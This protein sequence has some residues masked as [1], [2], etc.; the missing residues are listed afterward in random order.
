MSPEAIQSTDFLTAAL[1]GSISSVAVLVGLFFYLNYHTRRD[2]FTIW[3]VAWLFYGVWLV[4]RLGIAAD[5]L[6]GWVL[7]I[8]QWCIGTSAVFLLWGVCRF[9]GLPSPQR[10]MALFL[11]FIYSWAYA[12][13]EMLGDQ[14]WVQCPVF[15]LVGLASVL[16]AIGFYRIRLDH[17]SVGATLLTAGFFLWGV[18]L[19]SFPFVQEPEAWRS[20]GVFLSLGLQLFIAVSMI[21]LMLEEARASAE[22]M[23]DEIEAVKSEKETLQVR[24]LSAEATFRNLFGQDELE[25]N[26]QM[27][28]EQLRETQ[29][30][31][32]QQERLRAL[33]QMAS[34]VAHDINNSLTPIIGYSDFLLENLASLPD[35]SRNHLQCIRTAAGDIAHMVEQVR[36]FYRRRDHHEPLQAV[37]LNRIATEVIAM[38]RPRWRDIPQK[39]GVVL[40]IETA[41]TKNLPTVRENEGELREAITNLVLNAIDAMPQ[42]GTLTI[43]TRVMTPAPQGTSE[44]RAALVALEVK[45]TGVGM[46]ELTRQRCLEPFFSTKGPRGSGLGLSMVYGLMRRHQGTIEIDSQPGAGTTVRLVFNASQREHAVGE[47]TPSNVGLPPLRILC[48]DDDRRIANM[49]QDLL[50][51]QRHLVEVADGGEKGLQAFR[52]ARERGQ[53]FQVVITDLGMPKVD[54]RQ[55]VRIVK[56][57]SPETPVIMLTGWGSMID[58]EGQLPAEVDAVVSKPPSLSRLYE[59]LAEVTKACPA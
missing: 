44:E 25:A 8:G 13:G 27:A 22:R 15:L 5:P 32:V 31:V 34:G 35:E 37:E 11:T 7:T 9:M 42:G 29:Q 33:G 47:R 53:P 28:Y 2:Y 40:K 56:A 43:G 54:G 24:M 39:E 52:D 49:L 3:G 55:I 6:T 1:M 4:L 30:T 48:I 10:S 12:S 51:S 45:D 58:Q 38:T 36:Q 17:K 46:D 23:C 41:L 57:E 18:Y 19:A 50:G 26:L 14:L 16:A 21:V 20:A 59:V